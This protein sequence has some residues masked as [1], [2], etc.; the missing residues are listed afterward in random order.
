MLFNIWE[1]DLYLSLKPLK[2]I[3]DIFQLRFLG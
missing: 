2:Q 1:T 3:R